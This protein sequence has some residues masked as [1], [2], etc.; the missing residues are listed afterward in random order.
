[1][2]FFQKRSKKSVSN[3]LPGDLPNNK[4]D[5]RHM[6]IGNAAGAAHQLLAGFPWFLRRRRQ[7]DTNCWTRSPPQSAPMSSCHPVSGN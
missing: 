5:L 4:S 1:M 3:T 6:A 2:R 7:Q